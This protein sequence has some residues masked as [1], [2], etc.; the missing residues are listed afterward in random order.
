MKIIRTKQ[1]CPH[2]GCGSSDA[3]HIYEDESTYCFSCETFEHGK[4][5]TILTKKSLTRD[6]LHDRIEHRSPEVNPRSIE[7][8]TINDKEQY[9]K[10]TKVNNTYYAAWRGISKK[11][12]EFYEV[13]TKEVN[14][15]PDSVIFPYGDDACKVRTIGAKNFY[16]EG[17]MSDKSLF[18]MER[19][20]PG[21]AKSITIT[22]GELDAM[23]CYQMMGSAYPCVS[24]RGASS[25]RIDCERAYKY[26]N[27]F[28]NIYLCFDNDKHGNNAA[29]EVAKLFDINKVK[30]VVLDEDLKD[31]NAYLTKARE[32]EF[33]KCWWNARGFMPKG[34]VNSNTDIR[35]ILES[36]S[37]DP[38]ATFPFPTLDAMTDG[39][40][41][42]KMYLFKAQEKIGKTTIFHAIEHHLI[43]TTDLN[44]GIIHLEEPEKETIESLVSYPLQRPAKL[45][46]SNV[47]NEE[48]YAAYTKMVGRDNRVH[49]YR[50]FGSDDPDTI[51]DV[52]RYLVGV[53]HCKVIFLDHISMIVSGIETEDER[54]KL[55]Y[56]ST[57]M[58][59]MTK[60][61]DYTLILISH[62]ND[63]GMT[64]GSR[65]ISKV[66]DLIV[67]LNRDIKATS[68]DK[69]NTTE[70]IVEGNRYAHHSGPAG[71][72][73]FDAGTYTVQEKTEHTDTTA[74]PF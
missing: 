9:G 55:D 52:M 27:S 7:L 63:D 70:L 41:S 65:N 2:P 39:I 43:T 22:E 42:G 67:M 56:L 64:R 24:V 21:S 20:S 66:A 47:S 68:Y 15:V 29:L 62:V 50:H 74:P 30:H 35:E 28:D 48:K 8:L 61:L 36:K 12:M 18:G 44:I 53:C 40:H 58:A 37:S 49:Y 33:T 34:I 25:A 57:R 54:K 3:Y 71:H 11:T 16:A 69:R 31:A 60:E 26:L 46:D 45:R 1:P 23:S 4:K 10:L 73:W 32:K 38:I 13:L 51:L 17:S 5:D 14:G 59:M 6:W 72:L 19:F